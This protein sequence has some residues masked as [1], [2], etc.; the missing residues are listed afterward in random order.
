MRLRSINEIL[1]AA[2]GLMVS[3][4]TTSIHS[5]CKENITNSVYTKMNNIDSWNTL[6]V[7]ESVSKRVRT[8]TLRDE[9]SFYHR[10][11]KT[12]EFDKR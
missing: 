1:T 4:V 2:Y 11:I 5:R 7:R 3:E 6:T 12:Y 9:E 10:S 8:Q